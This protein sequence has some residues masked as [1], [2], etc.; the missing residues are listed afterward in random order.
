[1]YLYIIKLR[2]LLNDS[3]LLDLKNDFYPLNQNKN[4]PLLIYGKNL[5]EAI[6][7]SKDF[8][9]S[10]L[11]EYF[12]AINNIPNSSFPSIEH[13][14]KEAPL[15][16]TDPINQAEARE[17]LSLLY[18]NIEDKL[19]DWLPDF[20]EEFFNQ[21]KK[22]QINNPIFIAEQFTSQVF[23]KMILV[24]LQSKDDESIE[25]PGGILNTYK[26]KKSLEDYDSKLKVL[27]NF[28]E[29]KLIK[30]N[31]P[32]NDA[33]KIISI[34]VMGS[35]PL[36]NS[37]AFSMVLNSD[38]EKKW[39]AETL[40]KELSPISFTTRL[41][42]QTTTINDL[43]IQIGQEVY[44]SLSLINQFK[45]PQDSDTQKNNS[46]AFGL[47]KHMCPGRRI[48]IIIAQI[49]LDTWENFKEI[50]INSSSFNASRD[51][52]LRLKDNK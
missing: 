27:F 6:L 42:S 34:A 5:G 46:F 17:A 36:S 22:V 15:F 49:F 40:F 12:K 44:V 47:G 33:W 26:S 30:L 31:R 7:K 28:V 48:S 25:F 20:T 35:E 38:H 8:I 39:N 1:M 16:K 14:F 13:Y 24:E 10:N 29:Q 3:S 50:K 45:L 9:P 11:L 51:L 52:V 19:I 43:T 23:K 18:K 32:V 21:V 2:E 4:P 37:L 41:C